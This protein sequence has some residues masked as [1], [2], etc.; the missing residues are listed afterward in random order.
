MIVIPAFYRFFKKDIFLKEAIPK[1]IMLL[2]IT[3]ILILKA[4]FHLIIKAFFI[5]H[6]NFNQENGC[7]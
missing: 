3:F 6:Y 1:C 5:F 4:L 2:N 7:F